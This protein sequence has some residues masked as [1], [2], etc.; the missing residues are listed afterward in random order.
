MT[1]S[2]TN[3]AIKTLEQAT[4]Y[5]LETVEALG[6]I[7]HAIK[8]LHVNKALPGAYL[9]QDHTDLLRAYL[10]LESSLE[11]Y[12]HTVKHIKKMDWHIPYDDVS[13]QQIVAC[14]KP[15]FIVYEVMAD[16]IEAL[17]VYMI[18]QNKAFNR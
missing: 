16:S 8:G 2:I 6:D 18:Q 11:R 17:E 3:P 12:Y 4:A 9:I 14:I 7:K 1:Q 13:I 15:E 5:I 10:A